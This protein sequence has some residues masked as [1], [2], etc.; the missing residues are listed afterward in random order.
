[1]SVIISLYYQYFRHFGDGLSVFS[2]LKHIFGG[3]D[4]K[5]QGITMCGSLLSIVLLGVGVI[6]LCG[7]NL[8]S[9]Y[10]VKVLLY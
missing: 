4:A 8:Y 1:M 2:T 6:A 10:E 3:R 9:Y 5:E 7:R